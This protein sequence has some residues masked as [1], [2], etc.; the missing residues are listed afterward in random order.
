VDRFVRAA[1]INMVAGVGVG[2]LFKFGRLLLKD[3]ESTSNNMRR[4]LQT[5]MRRMG[6]DRPVF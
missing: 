4:F 2:E 1:L 5:L 6:L 3:Q